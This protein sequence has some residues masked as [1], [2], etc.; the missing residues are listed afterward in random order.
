MRASDSPDGISADIVEYR[1]DGVKVKLIFR[2]A[3]LASHCEVSR[4]AITEAIHNRCIA[5]FNFKFFQV[6]ENG[7]RYPILEKEKE[8]LIWQ[9]KSCF[10]TLK[11][12][13][14]I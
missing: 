4:K 11:Y 2:Y 5:Y 13:L 6:L 7:F 12:L 8:I 10:V 3:L 9:K 14:T 1:G